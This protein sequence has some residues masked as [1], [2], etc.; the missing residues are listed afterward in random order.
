VES[1]AG[2][3]ARR[4]G[5]RGRLPERNDRIPEN[6]E[7]AVAEGLERV[8]I[9]AVDLASVPGISARPLEGLDRTAALS[10]AREAGPNSSSSWTPASFK[11][12]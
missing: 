1:R 6:Y 12:T 4:I 3:A 5:L 8:G 9:L 2:S 10:R 7:A 11:A